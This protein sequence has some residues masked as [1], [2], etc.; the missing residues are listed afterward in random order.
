MIS[1]DS[2]QWI[3]IVPVFARKTKK[4]KIHSNTKLLPFPMVGTTELI[5]SGQSSH[6]SDCAKSYVKQFLKKNIYII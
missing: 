2:L 5:A 6:C 4:T 1:F 3:L